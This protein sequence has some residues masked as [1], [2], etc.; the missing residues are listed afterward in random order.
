M[1]DC[2]Q[3]AGRDRS[4]PCSV[5][6]YVAQRSAASSASVSVQPALFDAA[7]DGLGRVGA[8]PPGDPT[9]MTIGCQPGFHGCRVR[10]QLRRPPAT[11]PCNYREDEQGARQDRSGQITLQPLLARRC[12]WRGASLGSRLVS[13]AASGPSALRACA[14]LSRKM[15]GVSSVIRLIVIKGLPPLYRFRVTPQPWDEHHRG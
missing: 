7:P 3:E 10:L 15:R 13:R 11:E 4:L 6:P 8:G 1:F 2:P 9:W 5:G 14:R 12:G